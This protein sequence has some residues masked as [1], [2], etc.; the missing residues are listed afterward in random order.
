MHIVL[1]LVGAATSILIL[2][3]LLAE[4]GVTLAGLNPFLWK[5]RRAWKRRYEG[6]PIYQIETPLELTALMVVGIACLDGALSREEKQQ[7]LERF[8]SEFSMSRKQAA[9]LMVSSQYLLGDGTAFRDQLNKV[10]AAALPEFTPEQITSTQQMLAT[11]AGTDA[12]SAD[13]KADKIREIDQ[14]F[15]RHHA[16]QGTWSGPSHSH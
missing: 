13:L 3:R 4:S 9:D 2:L 11:V 7:V 12:A 6:N 10:M 1:A 15:A 16:D 8:E 14:L 5:R